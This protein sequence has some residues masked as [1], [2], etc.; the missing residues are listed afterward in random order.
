MQT[1]DE[2]D[3]AYLPL[4]EA[5]FATNPFPYLEAARNRHPWLAKCS[6]GLVVNEYRAVRELMARED[7]M[8]M[9]HPGIVEFMGAKDTVWGRFIEETLQ[10]Q[11]GET[12]KRLREILG[13]AFTPRQANLQRPLMRKVVSRLLD[14]WVPKQAFDFEE[15]ASYF[16]IT[17]A[18]MM[19]GATPDVVPRLRSSLETIGLGFSMDRKY[20]PALQNSVAVMD[21]FVRQL[22]RDRLAG[23]RLGEESDLLDLLLQANQDCSMTDD[24]LAN[25]LIFL[26]VAGYDTS[27]NVLTLVMH[28]LLDRPADYERCAVD[29]AF[30]RKIVEETMRF[31]GPASSPRILTDDIEF[32][33]VRLPKEIMLLF[34][35]SVAARD[36]SAVENPNIFDPERPKGNAHVGFGLGPHICLG[37]F[38]ARAQIEEGLHLI[39]QRITKPKRA[40]ASSW[41]PF[42]GVW[43]LRGLPIEFQPRSLS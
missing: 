4:E 32:R 18:C 41:R 10:A 31:H 28:V 6:F 20:L 1:L 13:P 9:A 22:V 34:P 14:E 39:A 35:W 29:P 40:A 2:L 24:E 38:I 25:L 7:K 17:V 37:Q 30:C 42:P 8:R 21:E 5:S 27:K 12:H 11:S 33:D 3:L 23:Q 43:G 36:P 26:F 15:F 19:L 16:P